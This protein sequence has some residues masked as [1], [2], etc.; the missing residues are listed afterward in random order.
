[1]YYIEGKSQDPCYNL[2]LEEYIM[3]TRKEGA[4]LILWSNK[5]SIIMGKYQ[6]AFE[7][8]NL[9]AVEEEQIPVVRRIS[10]G[11]TVFHDEGNLN[12]SF[13]ADAGGFGQIEYDE[14]LAPVIKALRSLGVKAGKRKVCDI[15]IGEQKI[16]GSAQCMKKG[17]V[18]HHGTLLY[19]ADLNRL[20]RYLR[21]PGYMV[22][23]K[24]VKSVRSQVANIRDYVD[25]KNMTI[26]QFKDFLA[27]SIC[28]GN[29]EK[30]ELSRQEEEAIGTLAKEKYG[31]WE[32]NYGKSPKS[33]LVCEKGEGEE[34]ISIRIQIRKGLIEECSIAR[35]EIRLKPA[36]E[37]LSGIRF[38]DQRIRE[39]LH[40]EES[41]N[42]ET[43]NAI[44][45]TICGLN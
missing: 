6:N 27:K 21:P 28:S 20:R 32:W 15:A 41:L 35:G 24:S 38:G 17:R 25:D 19:D 31:T 16:S 45:E 30:I 26:G 33:T 3:E 44:L 8:L 34:K 18:L 42:R 12:F 10:G 11:G 39:I 14:F 40:Q 22:E 7:E 5:D 1:M 36:E 2:A 9:K 43:K 37:K 4:Y 29:V 13:L 23:S